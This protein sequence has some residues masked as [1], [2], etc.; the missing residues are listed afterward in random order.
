VV[1]ADAEL[2]RLSFIPL[3][4]VDEVGYIPFGT[5][6]VATLFATHAPIAERVR[7]LRALDDNQALGLAA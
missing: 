4:V 5:T 1:V 3:L 7:R 6:G 2:R